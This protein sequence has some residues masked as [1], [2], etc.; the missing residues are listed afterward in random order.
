MKKFLFLF[1]LLMCNELNAQ[2]Q[3]S[4]YDQQLGVSTVEDLLNTAKS[5]MLS[6]KRKDDESFIIEKITF[7]G[8]TWNEVTFRY[9]KNRLFYVG[10]YLSSSI[11]TDVENEFFK[12][13]FEKLNRSLYKKYS[14]YS[15]PT[16]FEEWRE[17]NDNVTRI[18]L[19]YI[20]GSW[21]SD[22]FFSYS[23]VELDKLKSQ[24]SENEL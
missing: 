24:N 21:G 3:R 7:G 9:F 20:Q 16:E 14:L 18:I 1:A 4:I 23:D 5:K 10:F 11:S 15:K 12:S 2:I 22:M 6:V 13:N 17:Y 8:I 19:R